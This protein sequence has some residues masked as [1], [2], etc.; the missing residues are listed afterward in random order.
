MRVHVRRGHLDSTRALQCTSIHMHENARPS[1][2]TSH[3][4]LSLRGRRAR[5]KEAVGAADVGGVVPAV[6]LAGHHVRRLPIAAALTWAWRLPTLTLARRRVLLRSQAGLAAVLRVHGGGAGRRRGVGA[7]RGQR[8][9]GGEE[10]RGTGAGA[11]Q[12]SGCSA[13]AGR[14]CR[15]IHATARGDAVTD[16]ACNTSAAAAAAA[17]A[18]ARHSRALCD[19]EYRFAQRRQQ[20]QSEQLQ[21]QQR[22]QHFDCVL[23]TYINSYWYCFKH[24]RLFGAAEA[25]QQNHYIVFVRANTPRFADSHTRL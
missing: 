10:A 2:L 14:G 22:R 13:G 16:R 8:G 11:G 5:A 1:V 24:N 6:G 12:P 17:A 20:Q 23:V 4:G 18:A 19:R 7:P 15:R 9:G 25:H 3:R 21:V